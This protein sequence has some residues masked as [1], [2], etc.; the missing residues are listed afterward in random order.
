MSNKAYLDSA[1]DQLTVLG[2]SLVH[3]VMRKLA[4]NETQHDEID[5]DILDSIFQLLRAKRNVCVV[6][7]AAN[8]LPQM[9]GNFDRLAVQVNMWIALKR[10]NGIDAIRDDVTH[11]DISALEKAF[12]LAKLTLLDDPAAIDLA[13]DMVQEKEISKD[14]LNDWPLYDGIR[15]SVNQKLNAVES[16]NNPPRHD[17]PNG[18]AQ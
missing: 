12:R 15:E 17:S 9:R 16:N 6:R 7:L 3:H 4:A 14:A 18:P 1:I 2:F 10:M 13:Y 8:S 5:G 11:W